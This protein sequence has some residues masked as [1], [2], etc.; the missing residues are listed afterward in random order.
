[1]FIRLITYNNDKKDKIININDVND[2][3]VIKALK[4]FV[5]EKTGI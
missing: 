3:Y 1:M 5:K 4:E 2:D